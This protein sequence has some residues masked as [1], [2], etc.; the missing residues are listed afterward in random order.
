MQLT[1]L[2]GYLDLV[3]LAAVNIDFL[4]QPK[5]FAQNKCILSLTLHDVRKFLDT[6]K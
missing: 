6:S 3:K 5:M 1:A 4:Q 2:S